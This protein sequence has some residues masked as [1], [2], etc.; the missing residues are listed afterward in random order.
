MNGY[1]KIAIVATILLFISFETEKIYC[2]F[3]RKND[4]TEN[5][6]L[7]FWRWIHWYIMIYLDY[8]FLFFSIEKFDENMLVFFIV[9]TIIILHWKSGFCLLN[10]LELKHYNI[11]IFDFNTNVNP[12]M[13]SLC[14][15]R[16][17][18][19]ILFVSFIFG[20]IN[21]IGIM[22]LT[23]GINKYFKQYFLSF[24][25]ITAAYYTLSDNIDGQR[26]YKNTDYVNFFMNHPLF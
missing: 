7:Y 6:K 9:V 3:S 2:K 11:D 20:S 1:L 24:M 13:I 5:A 23:N 19:L 17:A 10:L 21:L 18:N 4:K 16:I 25:L 8:Y 15:D 12:H 26:I 22:T 14:N